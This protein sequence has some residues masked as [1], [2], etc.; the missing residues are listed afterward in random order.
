VEDGCYRKG[1][2][3]GFT[4]LTLLFS[5]FPMIPGIHGENRKKAKKYKF[6]QV[7][8]LSATGLIRIVPTASHE[9]Y[10]SKA[11]LKLYP[12]LH[13]GVSEFLACN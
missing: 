6:A 2:A 12:T 7:F 1:N 5:K 8:M 4:M 9:P 11:C 3:T 13:P 10:S